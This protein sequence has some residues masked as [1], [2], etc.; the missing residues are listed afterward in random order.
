[1]SPRASRSSSVLNHSTTEPIST[2]RNPMIE[3]LEQRMLLSGSASEIVQPNV[4]FTANASTSSTIAGYRPAQIK[5]AYGL[6]SLGTGAG[7]TIAIVDA[8]N[9]P[10]IAGDL[11]TFDSQFGL[12]SASLKVVNESGG[13]S[14]PATNAGWDTEISL[15]VEWA[16]AIAPGANILLVET[17][18]SSFSKPYAR[19]REL[20]SE[21]RGRVGRLDELGRRRVFWRDHRMTAISPRPPVIRA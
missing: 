20:C 18:S 12:P 19:R 6:T 4:L 8:Y 5:A 21:C 10:N 11:N 13:T 15:D 2:D 14:L 1:M 17:S 16:H 9:D 7:Q 3:P